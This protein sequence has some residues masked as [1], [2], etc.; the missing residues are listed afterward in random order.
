M[1]KPK[2][3]IV[4]KD[5]RTY[6]SFSDQLLN[7]FGDQVIIE[8]NSE[9]ADLIV[10]SSKQVIQNENF[11]TDKVYIPRRTISVEKLEKIYALPS[12]TECLIINNIKE[13]SVE[14]ISLFQSLN[15]D[16]QMTPLYPGKKVIVKD[17]IVAIVP[18]AIEMV[19]KG[20]KK[21]I[22][23]GVRPMAFGCLLE[24]AFRFNINISEQSIYNS[25]FFKETINMA[26]RLFENVQHVKGLNKQLDSIISTAS[27]GI[28]ATDYKGRI[29]KANQAATQILGVKHSLENIIGKQADQVFPKLNLMDKQIEE[30]KLFTI[31]GNNLVVNKASIFVDEK[32]VGT[33]TTF[34]DSNKIQNLE[35]EIR[36]G[37]QAKGLS[38]QYTISDIIGDSEKIKE[39]L[40]I[41]KKIAKTENTVLIQGE[42]GTGKELFAHAIHDLSQRKNGPFLPINFAGLPESLAESEIFGYEDGTFTGAKRGGK[43]GLFELAHNGTIF[44]DEIGDASP[45]V[46]VLLLR[47]LQEKQVMRI[48]G[49][50]IIP[51]N[52]RVIAATNRNLKDLIA[53]GKFREDLYYRLF[54]LPLRIPSL[55]ERREDIPELLNY[56]IAKYSE[57]EVIVSN[58]VMEKLISYRWPGNIRELESVVQ[59]LLTIKEGTVL[60]EK[61]LPEQFKESPLP[62]NEINGDI[63]NILSKEGNL[64]EF[65]A[66]LSCLNESQKSIGRGTI[67]NYTAEKGDQLSDQKVRHRMAVLRD[68]GLIYSGT[69]GKGS[70]ITKYGKM[71]LKLMERNSYREQI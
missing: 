16:L 63:I 28:I 34:Q 48:G 53:K 13:L 54:V 27:D 9:N 49:R 52:V 55:R 38:S 10:A 66:I 14:M 40:K 30:N 7:F 45:S 67:V 24:I 31:N 6:Q 51:V 44:L 20:I 23:I 19:P 3:M 4:S 26:N 32:E 39:T 62:S 70:S 71:T 57:T 50:G 25:Y 29:L 21:V 37:L 42:N 64:S 36:K 46:Q 17:S 35:H 1:R 68:L 58:Q 5:K 12:G 60:E 59:Y 65:Q 11:P 43:P 2:I 18:G 15:F 41:V 47:V 61:D 22:N 8:N 56:F 33:V 69:K